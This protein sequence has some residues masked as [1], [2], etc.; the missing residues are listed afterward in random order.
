MIIERKTSASRPLPMVIAD[1]NDKIIYVSNRA[2]QTMCGI[3]VG[4]S[5]APFIGSNRI[6]KMALLNKRIEMVAPENCDFECAAIKI[7]GHGVNKSAEITFFKIEEYDSED[8]YEDTRLF[9]SFGE[10]LSKRINGRV[11]AEDFVAQIIE[12]VQN[13]LRFAYRRFEVSNFVEED[14]GLYTNLAQLSVIVTATIVTLNELNCRRPIKIITSKIDESYIF[15]ISIS[16]NIFFEGNGFDALE[17]A[18]PHIAMKL[19]YVSSLCEMVGI[20]SEVT[21]KPNSVKVRYIVEGTSG[22]EE[23]ALSAPINVAD[24]MDVALYTMELFAG[25]TAQ[26][27]E[28]IE[29]EQE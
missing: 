26:F 27:S 23:G 16:D 11:R 12:A 29:E 17:A 18:Y 20:C 25:D 13:D 22:V 9:A 28:E 6:S 24:I 19:V 2:K 15:D 4:D 1:L 21:V 14:N 3:D 5:I 7:L 8:F 10:T